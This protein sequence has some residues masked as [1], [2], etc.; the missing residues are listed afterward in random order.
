MLTILD[1]PLYGPHVEFDPNG[2]CWLWGRPLRKDG[3]AQVAISG[4]NHLLH[5]VSWEIS[6]GPIPFGEG[7]HGTCVCHRC[8]VRSCINPLHLFLGS[9]RDN[10]ADM[11]AKGRAR[12][13]RHEANGRAVLTESDVEEIRHFLESTSLFLREIGEMFGVTKHTI[14]RIKHGRA[15]RP[16]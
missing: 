9:N 11:N 8:D 5:R 13:Q 7:P 14:W 12:P 6:H 4:K 16:V 10:N 2:G 3:Y 1:H 15:W